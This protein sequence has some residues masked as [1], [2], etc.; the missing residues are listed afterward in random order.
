M[1][2]FVGSHLVKSAIH[3]WRKYLLKVT[4]YLQKLS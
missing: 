1:F 3:V 4:R 2:K